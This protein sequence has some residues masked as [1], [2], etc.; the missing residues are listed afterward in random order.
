MNGT[1]PTGVILGVLSFAGLAANEMHLP[2]LGAFFV[3][4]HTAA[5]ASTILSGLLA[6]IAGASQG[7]KADKSAVP[8]TIDPTP[9]A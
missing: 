7:Y 5:T 2:V 6:L 3:D 8:A 4:P 9:K 1:I